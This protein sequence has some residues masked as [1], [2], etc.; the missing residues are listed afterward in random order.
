MAKSRTL[1]KKAPA[2]E[3]ERLK[4]ELAVE[5]SLERV[6]ARAMAMQKS[7]ELA[8]TSSYNSH[9]N[10]ELTKGNAGRCWDYGN[11]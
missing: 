2:T 9:R 1:A 5:A 10:K 4:N 3:L 6:R 7:E 11:Y 8:E